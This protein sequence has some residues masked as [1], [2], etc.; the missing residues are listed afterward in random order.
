MSEPTLFDPAPPEGDAPKRDAAPN[1]GRGGADVDGD[2]NAPKY[3][4]RPC[5]PAVRHDAPE[6]SRVAA[7]RIS[8]HAPKQR[9]DVLAFILSMGTRGATDA[10]V[11]AGLKIPIQSVNPRRGELAELGFIALNGERRPSP[12]GCPC[13]VWIASTFATIAPVKP[14]DAPRPEGGS[15]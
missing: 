13:R 8:G 14:G 4:G 1:L 5:S 3:S 6:T 12:S 11:A 7:Q 10:E 9:A 15:A 2:W